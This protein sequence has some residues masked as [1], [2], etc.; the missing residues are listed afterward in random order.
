MEKLQFK[1]IL[2]SK[3]VLIEFNKLF[4]NKKKFISS[5]SESKSNDLQ[6]KNGIEIIKQKISSDN[7]KKDKPT[8]ETDNSNYIFIDLLQHIIPLICLLTIYDE[9]YD[10]ISMYAYLNL[11]ENSINLN[12]FINQIQSCWGKNINLETINIFI[13]LYKQSMDNNMHVKIVI[14]MVKELFMKSTF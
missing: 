7:V 4:N 3:D 2:L 1:N 9:S 11:K 12:I 14:E 5:I 10:L 13:K 6:I 8:T